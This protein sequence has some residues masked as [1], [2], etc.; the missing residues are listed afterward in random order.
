MKLRTGLPDGPWNWHMIKNPGFSR[1]YTHLSRDKLLR[2]MKKD[3][4]KA[5]QQVISEIERISR[6]RV[7]LMNEVS[8]RAEEVIPKRSALPRRTCRRTTCFPCRRTVRPRKTSREFDTGPR[9]THGPLFPHTGRYASSE[10]W[11]YFSA[12]ARS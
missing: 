9:I 11:Y 10:T 6:T 1:K 4:G 7:D 8:C 5:F 12:Q 3:E 2:I